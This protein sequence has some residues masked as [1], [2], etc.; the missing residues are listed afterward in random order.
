MLLAGCL[1]SCSG[2]ARK[3]S[4]L[5]R[6]DQFFAAEKF[7]EAQLEYLSALQFT[8]P[9]VGALRRLGH[10]SLAN[11]ALPRAYAYYSKAFALQ[12]ANP[13]PLAKIAR[14]VL[15]LGE[16]QEAQKQAAEALVR[17]PGN[18]EALLVLADAIGNDD[19]AHVAEQA[20]WETRAHPTAASHLAWSRIALY[21]GDSLWAESELRQALQADPR[22][23][24]AQLA[25]AK[26]EAAQGH[27]DASRLEFSRALE[28]A[29]LRSEAPIAYARFL[30]DVD[31]SGAAQAYLEKINER[32]PDFLFGWQLQA[33]LAFAEKQWERAT[34][35]LEKV[36]AYD[37]D[38][39]PARLLES[40]ISLTV[41]E[42]T[43]AVGTLERL[44]AAFPDVPLLNYRLARAYLANNQADEAESVLQKALARTPDFGSAILLLAQVKVEK[45]DPAFA[46]PLLQ[47][48]LEKQPALST[49]RLLLAQAY[50]ASGRGDE[51]IAVL[52]E[53]TE[54]NPQSADAFVALGEI[55]HRNDHVAEARAA[56]QRAS[57]LDPAA[58]QPWAALVE[59]DLATGDFAAATARVESR[60]REAPRLAPAHFLLG[61]IAYAQKNWAAAEQAL[62]AT[63]ALDPH[64][65]GAAELLVSTHLAAENVPLAVER[66]QRELQRDPANEQNLTTLALLYHSTGQFE[67]ARD[68]YEKLLALNPASRAALN[69]LAFLYADHF[70]QFDRAYELAR[71]AR[72]LQPGDPAVA[73]TLG[74]VLFRQARYPEAF[75]L[76]RE[77]ALRLPD[78]PEAQAHF[79]TVSYMMDKLDLARTAFAKAAA[80]PG[81][82]AGKTEAA[83]WLAFLDT[84]SGEARDFS[85]QQ[86]EALV[87]ERPEDVIARTRL[88]EAYEREGLVVQA[89]AAFEKALNANPNLVSAMVRLAKL[90]A[91]PIA[92]P[93]QA[94]ALAKRARELAPTDPKITAVLGRIASQLGQFAWAYNLL[95]MSTRDRPEDVALL[96][97]FAC[98]TYGVGKT[99]EAR[100]LLQRVVA[101]APPPPIASEADVYLRLLTLAERPEE[102][103]AHEEEIS[104]LRQAHPDSL[105]AAMVF[106]AWQKVKG[107]PQAAAA[108]Y[109]ELLRRFP[110][111]APAQHSLASILAEDE[112]Q[113]D[114]A[115]ELATKARQAMP[116]DPAVAR[117]LGELCVRRKQYPYGAQ[118]LQESAKAAPLDPRGLYFLAVAWLNTDQTSEAQSAFERALQAGLAEPLATLAKKA[119]GNL[120]PD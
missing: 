32:A 38:S 76:L 71:R 46:A 72:L 80:A 56:F 60:L 118:L 47:R 41:G 21:R 5:R 49:A 31:G 57:E 48:L 101:A 114:R 24:E 93:A 78:N 15:L 29:P 2:E 109:G 39:I 86:L 51:A 82:S 66:L 12:P 8:P 84:N 34:H 4:H 89:A 103:G 113:L 43:K 77:A 61:K 22:F 67:P 107:Q 25:L 119:V 100:A 81:D 63:L 64:L 85:V 102:L 44:V 35:A 20:L 52:R 68:V 95:Q 99:Q 106:A 75:T 45:G 9:D 70:R 58:L 1:C 120:K 14:V 6:G 54:R 111:F 62:S 96:F 105:P 16:K 116:A 112:S 97:D 11:G 30:L 13:E 26:L 104:R 98:A 28:L 115:Y 73:D 94:L 55:L 23:A 87:Q 117:L 59:L 36:F 53:E 33:E 3:Q 90:Y 83:R 74:W 50:Q 69:N 110:D 17:M 88:G 91:G 7:P 42:P 37:G 108:T 18:G 10:I 40:E 19:D 92:K 79:G 27:P 65:A